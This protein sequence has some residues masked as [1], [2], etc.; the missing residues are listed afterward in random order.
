V[1]TYDPN[2]R[3]AIIGSRE[4][5]LPA[6]TAMTAM[7]D[8]VKLSREDADWLYPGVLGGDVL[9]QIL[10]LGPKIA[11]LTDGGNGSL[12]LTRRHELSV[13]AYR[14]QVVDTIGAGDTF[15]ASVVTAVSD[16]DISDPTREDLA[17]LGEQASAAAALC[18]GRAGAQP[19]T[20][21]EI[22]RFR[23]RSER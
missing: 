16:I 2:I 4:D 23:E 3:P 9:R 18:V 10:D 7:S 20:G 21:A 5:E 1:I 14:T 19:P 22:R 13:S 11:I 15:M 6:F 12:I 8:V 17:E